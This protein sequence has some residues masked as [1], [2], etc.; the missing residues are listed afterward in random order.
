MAIKISDYIMEQEISNASVA[1]IELARCFAEMEVIS[2]L[3]DCYAKQEI[4]AEYSSTDI[5]E[6]GIFQEADGAPLALGMNDEESGKKRDNIFAKG[7]AAIVNLFKQIGM[8]IVRL[9][10]KV[11]YADLIKK[12]EES[13]TE[14]Y[15]FSKSV[16]GISS[17]I[18]EL[19]VVFVLGE[20]WGVTIEGSEDC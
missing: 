1:D 14:Y 8:A 5:S 11:K 6:F 16:H 19:L 4:I 2:A 3:I 15:T 20:D 18:N 13:D 10:S 7:W 17:C 9:F 12:V